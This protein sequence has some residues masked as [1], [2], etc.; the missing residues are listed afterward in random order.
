MHY[1]RVPEKQAEKLKKLL[2]QKMLLDKQGRIKHSPS[3]VYFPVIVSN[4]NIKKLAMRH[5]AT[6]ES[7]KSST[8]GKK[9]PQKL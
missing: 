7:G 9:G 8:T 4:S 5:G 2:N 3:Y 6:I 1:I